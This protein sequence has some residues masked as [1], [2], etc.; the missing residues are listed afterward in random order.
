VHGGCYAD[1]SKTAS[2]TKAEYV[3]KYVQLINIRAGS[4]YGKYDVPG[5]SNPHRSV[6]GSIKNIG[7]KTINYL[8]IT[9]YF[10]DKNKKRVG[11]KEATVITTVSLFG[12]TDKTAP[13]K[14]NYMQDFGIDV[15]KDAPAAWTGKVEVEVKKIDGKGIT[16]APE[17]TSAQTQ[18]QS[19][20]ASPVIGFLTLAVIIGLPIW[21]ISRKRNPK[22]K[23]ARKIKETKCTCQACG[24]VWYYNTGEYYFIWNSRNRLGSLAE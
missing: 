11:E 14:P 15:E 17:P 23:V 24:N 6:F 22:A 18:A 13:L 8:N 16:D 7:D 3:K 9:I 5:V 21:L 10:L 2:V 4:G 1:D 20:S 12:L 19:S